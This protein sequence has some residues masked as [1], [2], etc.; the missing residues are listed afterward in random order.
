MNR[1]DINSVEDI[2][3]L[4][5]A[6]NYKIFLESL[7][8]SRLLTLEQV[9]AQVD[10]GRFEDRGGSSA[11]MLAQELIAQNLLTPYQAR[12]LLEKRPGPFFLTEAYKVLDLIGEGGMGH[13]YLCEHRFLE[14]L[15]AVKVL[16]REAM[17]VPGAVERLLREGRAAASLDHPNIARVF[18]AGRSSFGPFLVMELVD[19]LNLHQVVATRG[20]LEVNR[21]VSYVRDA[22]KGLSHA[23]ARGMIHRDI[24][25]S[26]IMVDRQGAVKL[27]DLGLVRYREKKK[28]RNVTGVFDMNNILGTADFISPEQALNSSGVD[29]RTDIYSLGCTLHFLLA[30]QFPFPQGTPMEKMRDHA[31]KPLPPMSDY[32]DDVP[33]PI[34][35]IMNRM[36]QKLPSDRYASPYELLE[37]LAPHSTQS[38]SLLPAG[39]FPD[40]PEGKFKLGL[41]PLQEDDVEPKTKE[42]PALT[43]EDT[44]PDNLRVVVPKP[45]VTTQ[46]PVWDTEATPTSGRRSLLFS[47][48]TGFIVFLI[49]L[50]LA[51][52]LLPRVVAATP[53]D[54]AIETHV[55]PTEST[56]GD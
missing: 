45:P 11:S 7:E 20:A 4:S 51:L 44:V 46:E 53:L 48:L 56:A 28:N 24:K 9:Y 38:P 27:L 1:F 42:Y 54:E 43:S 41:T 36:V 5:A 6:P 47:L 23:H 21:A 17:E 50:A 52:W 33:R 55:C 29:I 12:L 26:N 25:P 37:A 40:P 18:D 10:M 34:L 2:R 49:V 16:P 39:I 31:E 30:G 14:R 35:E 32:R 13:V 3:L 22:A 19:G 15:V 8:R